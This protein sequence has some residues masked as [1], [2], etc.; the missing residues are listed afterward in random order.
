MTG[1]ELI[2]S[3]TLIYLLYC[4]EISRRP[5]RSKRTDTLLPYTPLFRSPGRPLGLTTKGFDQLCADRGVRQSRGQYRKKQLRRILLGTK[6]DIIMP[7]RTG[8]DIEIG[9]AHV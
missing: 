4:C 7:Q 2:L 8:N 1:T 6:R 9:R 3:S 5:P